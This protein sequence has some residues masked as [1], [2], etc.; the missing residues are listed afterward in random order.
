MGDLAIVPCHRTS[1]DPLIYGNFIVENQKI[2][3]IYAKNVE[4]ANYIYSMNPSIS[5]LKC[6]SC[7]YAPLCD[8]GCLG[9]QLERNHDLFLPCT[10]VCE[11]EKAK[12][13]FLILKYDKM[14]I[15]DILSKSTS[16][17]AK[18]ILRVIKDIRQKEG[19]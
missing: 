12:L 2:T 10:S 11:M 17:C 8:K 18:N 6:S 9:A 19:F 16:S 3:G 1:Y 15:L 5:M 4:L 14:G 13:K 7:A